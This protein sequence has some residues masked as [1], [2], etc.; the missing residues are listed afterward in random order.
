MKKKNVIILMMLV[1]LL[2]IL[3]ISFNSGYW[4]LKTCDSEC[5]HRGY[6]MGTC[7]WPSE[8][9]EDDIEIGS[10]LVPNSR[11]CGNK[12]QCNCYC[13]Y[14]TS[15]GGERDEHGC[16][17]AAG[18]SWNETELSC[19]R[20]WLQG[21]ARYQVTNFDTCEAADYPVMESYPRQCKAPNGDIFVEELIACTADA[22][23]CPDGTGVGR[24]PPDCEFKPCPVS[25]VCE[26]KDDC[27]VFG[28]S[29]DCNC[30]CYN[31]DALPTSTGGACF[32]A[33]P[34]SCECIEE[35]CVGVFE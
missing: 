30:E 7:R 14:E 25:K 3:I 5:I 11:H 10:C 9:S 34:T 35:E 27:V 33:A 21:E 29:G 23:I 32:C 8:M 6:D 20:E 19:V 15:I 18:Y 24:V 22:K 26:V 2:I 17:G 31:K 13:E 12:G 16:L 4:N 1:V 28:E